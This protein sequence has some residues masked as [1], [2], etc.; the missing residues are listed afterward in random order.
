M[1]RSKRGSNVSPPILKSHKTTSSGDERTE[2][3]AAAEVASYI[4]DISGELAI[5]AQ[6]SKLEMLAY[7]LGI[8]QTEAANQTQIRGLNGRR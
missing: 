3:A 1:T 7:L 6:D 2:A 4:A 8:V 5:L